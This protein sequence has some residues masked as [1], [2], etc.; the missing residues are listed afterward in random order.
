[1]FEEVRSLRRYGL[2]DDHDLRTEND[3]VT[4]IVLLSPIFP[5]PALPIQMKEDQKISHLRPYDGAP[6]LM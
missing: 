2:T 4:P 5:L 6:D 1:M 3:K